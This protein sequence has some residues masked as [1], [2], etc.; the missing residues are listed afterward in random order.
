[1]RKTLT[2]VLVLLSAVSIIARAE[3]S[4]GVES[5][6]FLSLQD[7]EAASTVSR[8]DQA[9]H[10]SSGLSGS[11]YFVRAFEEYLSEGQIHRKMTI[12]RCEV[13]LQHLRLLRDNM[14]GRE[15]RSLVERNCRR[16]GDG[17]FNVLQSHFLIQEAI[18]RGSSFQW[19]EL[20][21]PRVLAG[22]LSLV[23][24][25]SV[26][27][28]SRTPSVAITAHRRLMQAIAA[29]YAAVGVIN[30]ALSIGDVVPLRLGGA[31]LSILDGVGS[32]N[33]IS[34]RSRVITLSD[35]PS[36]TKL[37]RVLRHLR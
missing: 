22:A 21:N 17:S 32:I 34:G 36:E 12:S 10:G 7:V 14:D 27:V 5:V 28:L 29:G 26:F 6:V 20:A 15:L 3:D 23:A 4:R 16:I 8:V 30:V 13:P 9:G 35:T 2:G 1:M 24:A 25:G 33:T 19:G 11:L 31:E 18:N 37:N